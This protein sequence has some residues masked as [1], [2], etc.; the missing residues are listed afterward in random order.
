MRE[1]DLTIEQHKLLR[2]LRNID[3]NLSIRHFSTFDPWLQAVCK[4]FNGK[5]MYSNHSHPYEKGLALIKLYKTGHDAVPTHA[6]RD[7]SATAE[8]LGTDPDG[9]YRLPNQN[10]D[11]TIGDTGK[12]L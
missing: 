8:F 2:D 5:A 6:P 10:E 1:S 3:P 9:V 12:F 11:G 4:V 7:Y